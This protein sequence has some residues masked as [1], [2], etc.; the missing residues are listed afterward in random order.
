MPLGSSAESSTV[1]ISGEGNTD[2]A[3]ITF[4]K[5]GVFNYTVEEVNDGLVGYTYDPSVYKVSFN[6]KQSENNIYDLIVE[7]KIYKDDTEVEEI[8]FD[9]QYSPGNSGGGGGGGYRPKPIPVGPVSPGGPGEKIKDPNKPTVPNVPENPEKPT[10]NPG[11]PVPGVPSIPERIR[12]IEKRIGEILNAGRKRPLT[13]EEKAELRKL[14]EVLGELRKKLS[15]R[16]NTSD[17]SHM[18]WY[19]LASVIS[20]LCLAFYWILDR[21]KKRR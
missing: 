11:E 12:E 6:V 21:K 15:R 8:L 16:V 19:A 4:T 1:E 3:P 2:F 7:R 17:A 13:P 9:N 14:G 10:P 20:F 5:P 18:L